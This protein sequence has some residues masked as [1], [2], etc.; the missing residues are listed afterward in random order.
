MKKKECAM[1]EVVDCNGWPC[2]VCHY[3]EETKE[4]EEKIREELLIKKARQKGIDVSDKEV[5]EEY[6]KRYGGK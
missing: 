2:N 5:E 1:R 4:E 3:Y 6:R